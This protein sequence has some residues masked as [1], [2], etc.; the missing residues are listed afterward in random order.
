MTMK[1][2]QSHDRVVNKWLWRFYTEWYWVQCVAWVKQYIQERFWVSERRG[3]WWD[4]YTG[5]KNY[6]NT[7]PSQKWKKVDYSIWK[8]PPFGAVVFFDKHELNENHWHVAVV[9]HWSNDI[10]IN[11]VEENGG[12]WYGKYEI[13]K[14]RKH[15]RKYIENWQAS[16]VGWY[17]PI[18]ENIVSEPEKPLKWIFWNEERALD[19]ITEFEADKM[20]LNSFGEGADFYRV[21]KSYW[22][23]LEYDPNARR[24]DYLNR[25]ARYNNSLT[26]L[27]PYARVDIASFIF[28]LRN[29]YLDEVQPIATQDDIIELMQKHFPNRNMMDVLKQNYP[30]LQEGAD[31]RATFRRSVYT[32]N[33]H[34]EFK[35]TRQQV[36]S[37]I[38]HMKKKLYPNEKIV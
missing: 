38:V 15:S 16:V 20:M 27:L 14:I 25:T 1:E 11:F 34:Y 12:W 21:C 4:A 7:F 33:R 31:L 23:W 9:D 30:Q 2:L 35:M 24:V 26:Q 3:F 19:T 5:W 22:E 18:T 10:A 17:E 29:S 28:R 6:N 36:L 32:T 37:S 13:D 8:I